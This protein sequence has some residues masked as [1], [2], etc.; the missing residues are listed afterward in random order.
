MTVTMAKITPDYRDA[1]RRT[2]YYV[3]LSLNKKIYILI[4]TAVTHHERVFLILI[5]Y[6][7]IWTR[8]RICRCYDKYAERQLIALHYLQSTLSKVKHNPFS[9]GGYPGET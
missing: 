9:Q 7:A 6:Q 4:V 8:T 3:N 1:K 5:S 2:T